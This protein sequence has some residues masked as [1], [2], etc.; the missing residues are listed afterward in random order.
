MESGSHDGLTHALPPVLCLTFLQDISEIGVSP[1]D[2]GTLP[3]STDTVQVEG[4]KELA[5]SLK[6]T[7]P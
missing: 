7:A 3:G 1:G 4:I 5:V 2:D 6:I